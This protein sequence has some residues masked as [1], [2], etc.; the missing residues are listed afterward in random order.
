MTSKELNML[1]L[2]TFPGIYDTYIDETQWQDGDDTGSHIVF[3]DVF[4]PNLL[5][6]LQENDIIAISH[7]FEFIEKLI[8]THDD[9]ATEVVFFSILESLFY[10][11]NNHNLILPY[12]GNKSKEFFLH[13]NK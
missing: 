6:L 5:K 11:C 3:E 2:K 4:V 12:M 7:A 1:L 9:Y 13:L 8:D 10:R